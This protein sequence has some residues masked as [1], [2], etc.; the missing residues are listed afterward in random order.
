MTEAHQ[1]MPAAL[2]DLHVVAAIIFLDGKIMAA[3]RVAGG[4]SGLKWEFPG[5]KVED[6]EQPEAAL[7]REIDEELGMAINVREEL[8][9]YFTPLGKWNLRLHCFICEAVSAPR[10][11]EAHS[12]IRWCP[13]GELHAIDWAPPDIPAINALLMKLESVT[14][15]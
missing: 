2:I 3:K 8:G 4:P 1:D 10:R 12:E 6:G 13:P 9:S 11:L 14:P 15:G 7:I 5:G